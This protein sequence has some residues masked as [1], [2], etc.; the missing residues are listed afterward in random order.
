MRPCFLDGT[1]RRTGSIAMD[2]DATGKRRQDVELLEAWRS[3][4]PRAGRQ[5][6][7]R[8]SGAVVRFF[9]NKVTVDAADL[10][11]AT[12]MRMFETRDRVR[13]AGSFRSH[14]LGIARNVLREHIRALARGRDVDPEVDSMAKL[15][16]GPSTVASEREEQRLLLESL[17]RLS[18]DD[19]ILVELFY[20][21]DLDS[22]AVSEIVG[23]PASSVR[24]RLARARGRLRQLMTELATDQ[25]LLA[26]T[27]DG[28]EGWVSDLRA[29]ARN[30]RNR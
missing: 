1:S 10:V 12:F 26:S 29:K 21:E 18:I 15:A 11:H 19:Q 20:W 30:E 5:L 23:M 28:L 2:R 14:A 24:T 27:V 4:D 16:P 13:H 6:F 25:A 3:G 7:D 9:E 17:R 22:S 8:H